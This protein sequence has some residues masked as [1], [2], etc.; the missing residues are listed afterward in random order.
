MSHPNER[1]RT[2]L[3]IVLEGG[4]GAGKTT[5]ARILADAFR[6]SFPAREVV[7]TRE[8]GDTPL[9]QEIRKLLLS[10]RADPMNPYAETMLFLADRAEHAAAVIRPALERGAI[11]ICDRYTDS[12]RVY[13]GIGRDVGPN[14]IGDASDWVT[15]HLRPDLVLVLDVDPVDGLAR[16]VDRGH[17]DRIEAETLAFHKRVRDGFVARVAAMQRER[18]NDHVWDGVY[19]PTPM[20]FLV[21]AD[22][23][24]ADV[25][26]RIWEY[27]TIL[28]AEHAPAEEPVAELA[29]ESA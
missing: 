14:Q 4:E 20:Y 10:K 22:G 11:V 7:L 23:P 8:P 19:P 21:G 1:P 28:L 12:T 26:A 9:G 5:Q 25:A 18:R 13:Q 16:V 27:V 24:V 15:G 3:F 29:G 6:L 17:T 2:G